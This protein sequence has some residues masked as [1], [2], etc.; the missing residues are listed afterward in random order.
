MEPTL[1]ERTIYERQAPDDRLVAASLAQSAPA[2]FWLQDAPAQDYPTLRGSQ[3]A[4]LTVVGGGYAG[5]WTAVL[6]KRRNP[7]QRV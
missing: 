7:A 2:V 3:T 6:A 4:D 1:R 5:L